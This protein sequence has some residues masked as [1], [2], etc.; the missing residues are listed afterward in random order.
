M[1]GSRIDWNYF[2]CFS[3]R[4]FCWVK[5]PIGYII[6]FDISESDFIVKVLTPDTG[7]DLE[8]RGE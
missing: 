5:E 8:A 7:Y 6:F 3:N 1:A 4:L 2:S